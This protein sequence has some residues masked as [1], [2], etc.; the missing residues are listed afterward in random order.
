MTSTVDPNR[1]VE[2]A[3]SGMTCAACANRI[4][5]KLNKLD[6]VDA[7]VNYAT[8]QA[9]VRFDPERV[10]VA[11]L[12]G[13]VESAGYHAVPAAEAGESVDRSDVVRRRLL[14]AAV[15]RRRS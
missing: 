6:G 10:T 5:R 15:L 7:S 12:L 2:L 3:I 4:E 8:E 11:D 1:Q 13:A 9:A 14:V